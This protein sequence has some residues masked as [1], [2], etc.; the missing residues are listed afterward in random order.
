MPVL[1]PAKRLRLYITERAR[2]GRD[3]L[4]EAVLRKAH[5]LGIAGATAFRGFMGYGQVSRLQRPSLFEIAEDLPMLVEIIDRPERI[6]RL[7]GELA[8][9]VH[10]GFLTVDAVEMAHLD[11]R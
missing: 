3:P 10:E 1:V 7:L 11:G 9:I 2:L 8:G 4:Y 6:E 5:E